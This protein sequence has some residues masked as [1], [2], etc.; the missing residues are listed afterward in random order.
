MDSVINEARG[1]AT[2][3]VA[4]RRQFL[5]REGRPLLLADWEQALFL[6]FEVPAALLQRHVPFELDLFEGRAFVSLVVFTMRGMRLAR[7]GRLGRWLCAP[8]GEQRFLN[9]RTYVRHGGEAGIY[10]IAEWISHAICVP[11]GPVTYGLP[12]RWGRLAFEHAHE[13]GRV[14]GRVESRCGGDAL[15]YAARTT[16]GAQGW[17]FDVPEPGSMVS[18]WSS[19]TPRSRSTETAAASF[20]SGT[21]RG[22]RRGRR[23]N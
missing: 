11:F 7:G 12:Y 9:V 18:S 4:A 14:R 6:H 23:W 13:R 1:I 10:F 20:A 2:P 3:S 19:A 15:E 8:F 21:S 5:A 22:G 17:K 16:G